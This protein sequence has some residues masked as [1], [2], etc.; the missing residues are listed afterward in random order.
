MSDADKK[1]FNKFIMEMKSV[2]LT[3]TPKL[4]HRIMNGLVRHPLVRKTEIPKVSHEDNV[5]KFFPL[6]RHGAQTFLTRRK[7][8][9]TIL[10]KGV[11]DRHLK[12]IQRVRPA[13]V[14][15]SHFSLLHDNAPAQIKLQVSANFLPQNVTTL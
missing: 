3:M 14:C 10:C 6:P 12:R 13:A 5:D 9:N 15:C 1:L 2:I 11:M 8:L 4:S 7:T